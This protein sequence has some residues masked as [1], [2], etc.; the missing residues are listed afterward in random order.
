M[1]ILRL[2]FLVLP[3]MIGQVFAASLDGQHGS[4]IYT[5]KKN[6]DYHSVVFKAESGRVIRPFDFGISYSFDSDQLSPD[7]SYSVVNF[8]E[9][10]VLDSGGR[11]DNYSLYLCAFVR[12][13]DG[14][15][16][17]VESGEQ[18]GGG[19]ISPNRWVSPLGDANGVL[20]N[21]PPSVEETYKNYLSGRKDRSQVSNP[22]VMDYLLEGTSFQNLLVCDPPNER[23]KSAYNSLLI[24]L[25]HDGDEENAKAVEGALA[26]LDM[27]HDAEIKK[28]DFELYGR[29]M[30]SGPFPAKV[31]SGADIFFSKSHD[32]KYPVYFMLRK[33]SGESEVIDRYEVSGSD[34]NIESVFFYP[35]KGEKNIMVL[36][37]WEVNSRGLGTYGKLYQVYAY[38]QQDGVIVENSLISKDGNMSGL[39]GYQEGRE[40]S[41]S[42]KSAA[43][44]RKYIN[45]QGKFR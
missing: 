13:S 34:P 3:F 27:P 45:G 4:L 25:R 44:I 26:E 14:C 11:G 29:E 32:E 23:N 10:G 18:C 24:K 33:E 9:S 30:V 42:L 36:V 12:M 19:W 6:G 16:A 40:V 39:D 15:V 2:Y 5:D 7:K 41:F 8:S 21:E 20:F 17:A 28:G 43:A 35:I 31:M 1:R 22:K 37:S 38:K